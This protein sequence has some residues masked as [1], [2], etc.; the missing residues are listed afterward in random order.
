MLQGSVHEWTRRIS[1]T[2]L[3]LQPLTPAERAEAVARAVAV[4]PRDGARTLVGPRR[5]PRGAGAAAGARLPAPAAAV[6]LRAAPCASTC[7]RARSRI[8][9]RR[10]RDAR[11][12]AAGH[13]A[14]RCRS[15]R[16]TSWPR[17]RTARGATTSRCAFRMATR[18]CTASRACPVARRCHAT[19]SSISALLVL[20]LVVVLY[21]VARSIT[22]PLSDLARAADSVGRERGGTADGARRA[23]AA[24]RR[25]RLQHH[26]GPPAPLSRQP[27]AR[28]GGHVT[29]PEDPAHA[30]APAGRGA[31]QPAHA[32]AHR[33][34][35][36]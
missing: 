27:L 26:A 3:M 10:V 16:R 2:T 9:G 35:T 32:G 36:G 34:R 24:R 11:A 22:R 1:E 12:A 7:M 31:R 28:A 20:I 4:A 15:T 33:A 21:L 29:R 25:A 18:C 17:T 5:R 6:G 19:C 30:A 14:A 13:P 8:H 23:R